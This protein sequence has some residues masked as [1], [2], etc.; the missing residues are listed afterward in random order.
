MERGIVG[1]VDRSSV[2]LAA[3]VVCC[4]VA[5]L[6]ANAAARPTKAQVESRYRSISTNVNSAGTAFVATA[7]AMI[8]AK[9]T[10]EKIYL[11]AARPFI[12]VLRT[13]DRDLLR[14]GASGKAA[15]TVRTLVAI[16]EKTITDLGKVE[17]EPR[18][19]IPAWQQVI[20][21]DANRTVVVADR[22]WTQLG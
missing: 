17:T 2:A 20:S 19:G 15:A 7:G 10:G 13:A 14:M 4:C 16:D 11:T 3:T 5:V 22:L 6:P 18:T 1:S 8:T 12:D 9:A 21:D